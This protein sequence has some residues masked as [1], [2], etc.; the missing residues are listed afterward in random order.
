MDE[1][2]PWDWRVLSRHFAKNVYNVLDA[3]KVAVLVVADLPGGAVVDLGELRQ[4]EG[5]GE[6]DQ[7]HVG[8]ILVVNKQQRAPDDL[9]QNISRQQ[10]T[11]FFS[12]L[13]SRSIG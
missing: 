3:R 1:R 5:L 13:N 4:N 12:S 6:V 7:P 10:I 2:G 8:V 11:T 9:K